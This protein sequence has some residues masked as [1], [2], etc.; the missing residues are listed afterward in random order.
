MF[1][2]FGNMDPLEV[3]LITPTPPLSSPAEFR[4]PSICRATAPAKNFRLENY[5]VRV[6]AP[7]NLVVLDAHSAVDA[8]RRRGDRAMCSAAGR[9]WSKPAPRRAGASEA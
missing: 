3:A 5:G 4:L 7:A 6:G 2:S 9:W 1:Y 8:L